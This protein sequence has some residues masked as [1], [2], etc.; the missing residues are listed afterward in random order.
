MSDDFN[1]SLKKELEQ[2]VDVIKTVLELNKI[3]NDIKNP[4]VNSTLKINRLNV[5]EKN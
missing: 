2:I 5:L 1:V 4:F 3:K